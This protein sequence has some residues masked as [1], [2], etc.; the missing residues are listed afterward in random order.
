MRPYRAAEGELDPIK[1]AALFIRL[2]DLACGDQAVIPVVYRPRVVAISNKRHASLT[3]WDNDLCD[4]AGC[5]V[6]ARSPSQLRC[7]WRYPGP[8]RAGCARGSNDP[9]S[10]RLRA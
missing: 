8:A 3:G 10:L 7:S 9:T 4:L 1:R 6:S 5:L 2:N